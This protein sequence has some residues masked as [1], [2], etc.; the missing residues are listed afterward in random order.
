[1]LVGREGLRKVVTE[2]ASKLP[3]APQAIG[4]GFA[5]ARGKKEMDMARGV[6]RQVWPRVTKV[7]TRIAACGRNGRVASRNCGTKATKKTVTAT[8]GLPYRCQI[9]PGPCWRP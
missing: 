1:M 7:A 3:M 9:R 4:A 6:L 2:I 8:A 5:G